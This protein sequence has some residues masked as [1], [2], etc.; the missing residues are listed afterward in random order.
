MKRILF[1]VIFIS[2]LGFSSCSKRNDAGEI[3][4]SWKLVEVYDKTTNTFTHSPAGSDMNVVITFLDGSRFAGHTLRNA[5]T[6]GA[7]Q[8]NG[9]EIVFKNFSMTKI[10]EDEWGGSFL[11]VLN[12]CYLQSATPCLPSIITLQGSIMKIR[13]QVRYDITLEKL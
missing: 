11:S 1:F 13:T 3:S 10:A 8:Q 2:I 9:D 12:S 5:L 7:Y 6:D 4:G